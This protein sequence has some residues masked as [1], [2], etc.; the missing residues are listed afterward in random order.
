MG[1]R[2]MPQPTA[3]PNRAFSSPI[4]NSPLSRR[5]HVPSCVGG[6]LGMFL[7]S[8]D[9]WDGRNIPYTTVACV[10][11]I[12]YIYIYYVCGIFPYCIMGLRF[13]L[14]CGVC[15]WVLCVS[16]CELLFW[17]H[18]IVIC[19]HGDRMV[20]NCFQIPQSPGFR[21]TPHEYMVWCVVCATF[22]AHATDLQQ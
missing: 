12:T 22:V 16:L 2:Q 21:P 17:A 5:A 13:E 1:R 6:C 10:H 18:S 4:N 9:I 3:E 15:V 14:F 19:R 7:S 20:I 8:V 11:C